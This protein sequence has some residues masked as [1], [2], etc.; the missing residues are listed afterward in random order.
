MPCARALSSLLAA[1]IRV[2]SADGVCASTLFLH[3]SYTASRREAKP[4]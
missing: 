2:I 3:L 1:L 4:T